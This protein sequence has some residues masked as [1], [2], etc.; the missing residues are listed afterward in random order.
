MA[1]TGSGSDGTLSTTDGVGFTPEGSPVVESAWTRDAL[2]PPL[3]G[4]E[5]VADCVRPVA[6]QGSGRQ[7][8]DAVS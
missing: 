2:A 6:Q 3:A 4:I 5:T 7:H 1:V 8:D